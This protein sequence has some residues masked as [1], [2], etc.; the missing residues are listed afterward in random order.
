[1]STF[2]LVNIC[3]YITNGHE[4][5]F[6]ITATVSALVA[7]KLRPLVMSSVC[8]HNSS[9]PFNFLVVLRKLCSTFDTPT[10]HY[11]SATHHEI[12]DLIV[13]AKLLT[14]APLFCLQENIH[15]EPQSYKISV[16]CCLILKFHTLDNRGI[17]H[18][19]FSHTLL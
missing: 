16:L 18:I 13:I 12:Q 6:Y 9:L 14:L 17:C 7:E 15:T 3:V 1:M 4:R 2:V 11:I 8:C 19:L 5:C 10:V